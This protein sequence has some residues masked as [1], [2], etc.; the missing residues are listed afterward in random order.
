M[1]KWANLSQKPKP[2]E[3]TINDITNMPLNDVSTDLN[4]LNDIHN[5]LGSA[6][7]CIKSTV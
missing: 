1:S 5:I 4:V 7:V 6:T 3:I 2:L